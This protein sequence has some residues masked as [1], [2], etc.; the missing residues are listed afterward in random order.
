MHALTPAP[1]T[2]SWPAPA[3]P[4]NCWR[5]WA[6]SSWCSFCPVVRQLPQWR[7][8]ISKDRP[9]RRIVRGIIGVHQAVPEGTDLLA[10]LDRFIR[11]DPHQLIDGLP[12][13][14]QPAFHGI[15]YRDRCGVLLI[16]GD[17]L[18]MDVDGI[19]GG[20]DI[21]PLLALVLHRK[22]EPWSVRSPRASPGSSQTAWSAGPPGGLKRPP[23]HPTGQASVRRR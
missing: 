10:V 11:V 9:H 14:D 7:Q 1:G 5:R 8:V 23:A 13:D 17:A 6:A 22:R 12:N 4:C 19:Q 2:S 20:Q 21:R 15:L 3:C 16:G 18:Q